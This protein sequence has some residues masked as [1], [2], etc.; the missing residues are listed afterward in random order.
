M[1]LLEGLCLGGPR[2]GEFMAREH[3]EVPVLDA[4]GPYSREIGT[5]RWLE[6]KLPTMGAPDGHWQW[7]A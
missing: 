1:K 2:D 5:Y 4:G 3:R 7:E 6:Q